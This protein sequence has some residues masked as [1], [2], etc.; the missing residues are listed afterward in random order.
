MVEPG[1]KPRSLAHAPTFE[2]AAPQAAHERARG[3]RA[4]TH[5]SR[6]F[7]NRWLPQ[8]TCADC[9]GSSGDLLPP[10]PPAQKANARQVCDYSPHYG[11][12]PSLLQ[13]CSRDCQTGGEIDRLGAGACR[14]SRRCLRHRI[15]VVGPKIPCTKAVKTARRS[16]A[17]AARKMRA[18]H[19][20]DDISHR[21]RTPTGSAGHAGATANLKLTFH[22]DH[23]AGLITP[24]RQHLAGGASA[25]PAKEAIASRVFSEGSLMPLTR[26]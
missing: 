22:L 19:R 5:K 7:G 21:L 24:L 11:R 1:T 23:S 14:G 4:C 16:G 13:S 26:N 6:L 12:W 2:R 20:E 8:M 18:G 3:L 9:A 10:S 25:K 15:S 17:G